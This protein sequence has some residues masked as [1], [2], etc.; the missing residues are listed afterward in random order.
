MLSCKVV[1]NSIEHNNK[2]EES[3]Q[4]TLVNRGMYQ[5]LVGRLIYLLHTLPDIAYAVT[6]VSQFMHLPG[7]L[8]W[9]QFIEYFDI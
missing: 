7:N 9:K 5:Q 6:V 1:G 3:D 8:I 4:S 2:L